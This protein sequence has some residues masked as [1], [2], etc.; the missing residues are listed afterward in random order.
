[1]A[2]APKAAMTIEECMFARD[3][4]GMKEEDCDVLQSL[5]RGERVLLDLEDR[6]LMLL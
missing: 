3:V 5:R 2:S 4:V 6:A 1:M